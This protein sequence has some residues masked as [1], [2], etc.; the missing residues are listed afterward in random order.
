MSDERREK[1]RK[2]SRPIVKQPLDR[3][4]GCPEQQ[5]PCNFTSVPSY[6]RGTMKMQGVSRSG[7]KSSTD[8]VCTYVE[9]E[10]HYMIVL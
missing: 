4:L 1:K 7:F 6:P 5:V 9:Q 10:E 8:T 3:M 2:I